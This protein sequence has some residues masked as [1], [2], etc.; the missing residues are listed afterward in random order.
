MKILLT[1]V[2]GLLGANL[3]MELSQYDHDI[4]G[5]YNK[6]WCAF[7]MA[8]TKQCD[9]TDQNSFFDLLGTFKPDWIIH[10]AAMTDVNACEDNLDLAMQCNADITRYLAKLA[11]KV[12][13]HI[14]YISTDCIF[15]GL[16][17]NYSEN[18]DPNPINNY[19]KSKLEGEMAVMVE[20][21]EA[22]I[23]RTSIF[24]W[25]LQT[26][27]SLAEK[28]LNQLVNTGPFFGFNDVYF[29]PLLVNDLSSI[30]IQMIE[31]K[32]NGIYHLVWTLL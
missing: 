13:S 32:Y 6:N 5:I 16:K 17:G 18:D 23:I 15:D 24:G 8:A 11:T 14:L 3:M 7:P 2:S 26:K 10:C 25:N 27:F 12:N 30:L 28:V 1:G 21:P 29:S 31:K 9:L 4:L 19:A 20:C 22:L